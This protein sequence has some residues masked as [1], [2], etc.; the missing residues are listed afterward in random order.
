[1]QFFLNEVRIRV[2]VAKSVARLFGAT[3]TDKFLKTWGWHP[4]SEMLLITAVDLCYVVC[5]LKRDS[6]H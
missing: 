1:M 2:S 6:L 3:S 4:S 5:S